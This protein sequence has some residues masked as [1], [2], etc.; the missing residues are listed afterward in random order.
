MIQ[1]G[2]YEN[3]DGTG[4]RSV[5]KRRRFCDEGFVLKHDAAG[6]VACAN[7]GPNSNTSQ[8]YILLGPADW[9]DDLHVVFGHV[10]E[11]MDVIKDLEQYATGEEGDVTTPIEIVAS[12]CAD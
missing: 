7:S 11:G 6:V 9:L 5:F 2:D 8:F 3:G 4:G 12:G 10:T 1:G